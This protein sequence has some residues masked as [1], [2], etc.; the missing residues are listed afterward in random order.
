[1]NYA[2]GIKGNADKI[3]YKYCGETLDPCGRLGG[4]WCGIRNAVEKMKSK[5]PQY[6]YKQLRD[7]K[8]NIKK[9]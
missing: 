6:C 4:H 5:D 7:K 1:M 9:L 8:L 3:N 2:W